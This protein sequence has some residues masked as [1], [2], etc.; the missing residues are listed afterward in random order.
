MGV[1]ESGKEE[2]AELLHG[3]FLSLL[4][5]VYDTTKASYLLPVLTYLNE[6]IDRA[7][8]AKSIEPRDVVTF[9]VGEL[10]YPFERREMY[11]FWSQ[12]IS[13]DCSSDVVGQC[14]VCGERLKL[15]RT[16]PVR[17]FI[18]AE[19]CQITSFNWGAVR[20]FGR[21]QT[22]NAQ[23][24]PGCGLLAAQTLNHLLK[25]EQHSSIIARDDTRGDSSN[26]LNNQIA[27]FWLEKKPDPIIIDDTEVNVFDLITSPIIEEHRRP[28]AVITLN[29]LQEML[30]RPWTGR[31]IKNRLEDNSFYLAVLSA[32]KARLVIR[33]WMHTPI[34][35]L[36]K[37]LDRY[38][39]A[40]RIVSPSGSSI[41]A[42]SVPAIINALRTSN[43]NIVRGL[44]RTA[45]SGHAVPSGCLENAVYRMR[46]G[47][48]KS[49][50]NMYPWRDGGDLHILAAVIK[51]ALTYG[52]EE[53][54]EME[55]LDKRSANQSYL[56]GRLLAA[57]EEIQQRAARYRLNTT[58]VERYIG[59]ASTSPGTTFPQLIKL[60][61]SG[62][63]PKI[64]KE[65]MGYGKMREIMQDVC[66]G[67]DESGGFPSVLSLRGQGEFM[68]G[69][70]HQ[71]AE[72]ARQR[73]LARQ[74]RLDGPDN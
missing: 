31:E 74:R 68:L 35:S 9:S 38:I 12:H 5:D 25:N 43:P 32:N 62:H 67:I 6:F 71:R 73:E 40:L 14:S 70:Y 21:E 49:K 7:E 54:K 8:L 39:R 11:R 30:T 60:A 72:F 13:S 3:G 44:I 34:D 51:L 27:V 20:S 17:V 64:R 23:I 19:G 53:A 63:L 66:A 65:H 59:S 56:C 28:E 55:E 52:T 22:V 33:D 29:L 47:V 10:P 1:P 4:E 18:L 26:P 36:L 42:F 50:K 48:R 24:G 57:L 16:L 41:R 15:L 58:L 2:E 37:Y 61:E 45:Y 69:F 46:V